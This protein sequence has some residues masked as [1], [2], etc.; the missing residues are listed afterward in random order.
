MHGPL[1]VKYEKQHSVFEN[2]SVFVVGWEDRWATIA[3]PLTGRHSRSHNVFVFHSW[4]KNI[5]TPPVICSDK[6][7]GGNNI[8]LRN[9]PEYP[10]NQTFGTRCPDMD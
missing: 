2:G 10:S 7:E 1:N 8:F 3:S 9:N 6:F 5:S 4:R